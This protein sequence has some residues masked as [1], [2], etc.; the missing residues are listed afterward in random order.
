M[1]YYKRFPRREEYVGTLETQKD[2]PPTVKR[3]SG[4]DVAEEPNKFEPK[5]PETWPEV[6]RVTW[7]K[8]CNSTRRFL[9]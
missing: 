2:K 7:S 3:W 5:L 1:T 8:C 6:W 4:V 9:L